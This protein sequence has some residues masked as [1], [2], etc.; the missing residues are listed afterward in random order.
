MFVIFGIGDKR[1]KQHQLSDTEHCFHCNNTSHWFIS[2]TVHN[3]SLFF[4][5]VFPYK[6]KYFH[7]CPICNHGREITE[8][9]FEALKN[10]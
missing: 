10:S 1:V 2:K 8:G 9:Q 6:T 5:P 3:F 7:H 4:M